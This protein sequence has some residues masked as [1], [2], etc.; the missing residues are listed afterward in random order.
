MLLRLQGEGIHV[1]A[2]VGWHVLVVLEWLHQVEVGATANSETVLAVQL[3]LSINNAVHT[4]SGAVVGPVVAGGHTQDGVTLNDPNQLFNGMIKVQLHALAQ[5]SDGLITSELEL[6]NEVLMRQ[7]G[8]AAALV[9]VQE[10][11]VNP[12]GGIN[13]VG[14]TA[15]RDGGWTILH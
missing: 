13:I 10:D 7:L 3:Q 12:Q 9:S 8:E 4:V 2:N 11:I 14:D 5:A 6:L 1:D 15:S